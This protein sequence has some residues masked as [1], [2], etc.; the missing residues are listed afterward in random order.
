MKSAVTTG[1]VALN[2]RTYRAEENDVEETGGTDADLVNDESVQQ[3]FKL[4]NNDA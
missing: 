3:S 1:I 4:V 2:K